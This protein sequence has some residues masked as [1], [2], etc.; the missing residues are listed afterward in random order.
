MVSVGQKFEKDSAGQFPL[1]VSTGLQ[2][3]EDSTGPGGS[4]S[5]F[6]HSYSWQVG[7]GCR[8]GASVSLH[9]A[10]WVSS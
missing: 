6:T 10:A 5:K 4:S 1:G 9:R 3:S 2:S 8:L 7:V